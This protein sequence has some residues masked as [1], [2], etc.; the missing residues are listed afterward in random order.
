MKRHV[1]AILT[2]TTLPLITSARSLTISGISSGGF[3]ASQMATIY[4]DQFTGV[5]TVAGGVFF[6]AENV[7]QKN[8]ADYGTSAYFNYGINTE[9][10]FKVID[11]LKVNP[12]PAGLSA[13]NYIE[14]LKSNPLYQ[15]MGVCMQRPEKAHQAEDT[16]NPGAMDL[17]FLN[18]FANQGLIADTSNIS[19]QR[20]LIY[21][22]SN[23]RTVNPGMADK[24]QEF[25]SRLGVGE[26]ELQMVS[27]S[28]NHNFPTDRDDGTACSEARPP[29]VANCKMDLAGQVLNHLLD[30]PLVRAKYNESNLHIIAQADAPNSLATYGY[31]YA[32]AFCLNNPSACDVH[33]ALHGCKMSDSFDKEFQSA[34]EAKVQLTRI[35]GIQNYELKARSPQMGAL[36]FARKAGY[37]EYAE[38]ANNRLMILFPQT[39]ITSENY[40]GNPNGCWDWYGWTGSNYATNQGSEPSWLIQQIN[41]VQKN[42]RALLLKNF[43]K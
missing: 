30:R 28:G 16:K 8:L 23:D 41:L 37:A 13:P 20:V 2:L 5:A 34:Y 36:A 12:V 35:L 1:L 42:P 24:V 15:A 21:Q 7:F 17:G 29:Y 9:G 22:G 32:N 4:S 43:P 18:D 40:P 33:V 19:Q 31:L 27:S 14:P 11:P 3:M 25:Y 6:C 38:S 26:S 39:Q 10:I